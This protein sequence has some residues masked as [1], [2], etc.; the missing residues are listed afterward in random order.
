M[1]LQRIGSQNC[2]QPTPLLSV[3]F[4]TDCGW[5]TNPGEELQTAECS[6]RI[7][8]IKSDTL[9]DSWNR[10]DIEYVHRMIT[11]S[12]YANSVKK[13]TLSTLK[14]LYHYSI[15]NKIADKNK[16]KEYDSNVSWITPGAFRD[17]YEKIQAG[18]LLTDDEILK[19]I[20]GIKKIGGRYVKRNIALVFVLLEG[21]ISS[22]RT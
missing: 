9:I 10:E 12:R 11:E 16:G 18:D 7:L 22:R 8:G 19:L 13:D 6:R 20:Q 3:N 15:Y 4:W 14:R 17:R 2:F 21:G 5:R 1:N